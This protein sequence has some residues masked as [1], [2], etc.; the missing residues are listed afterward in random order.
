MVLSYEYFITGKYDHNEHFLLVA[1]V[2]IKHTLGNN[3]YTYS[4]K[5]PGANLKDYLAQHPN[6]EEQLAMIELYDS[7]CALLNDLLTALKTETLEYNGNNCRQ[8][9]GE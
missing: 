8:L 5:S 7:E 2:E 6:K 4:I 3:V 1:S 9:A